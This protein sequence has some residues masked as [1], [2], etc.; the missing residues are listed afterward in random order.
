MDEHRKK[1]TCIYKNNKNAEGPAGSLV[2][3][4]EREGKPSPKLPLVSTLGLHWFTIL[5]LAGIDHDEPYLCPHYL[6]NMC[7]EF[8]LCSYLNTLS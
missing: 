7:F 8:N 6:P 2:V 5:D 4:V 3:S 1:D